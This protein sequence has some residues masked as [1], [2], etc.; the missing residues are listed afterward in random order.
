LSTLRAGC[1][2]RTRVFVP[3]TAREAGPL[4][5]PL[6]TAATLSRAPTSSLTNTTCFDYEKN[7]LRLDNPADAGPILNPQPAARQLRARQPH[8]PRA[9]W[10]DDE[11]I[12]TDRAA[13]D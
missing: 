10:G 9:A 2:H 5:P 1:M 7:L 3:A 11:D 8:A 12:G 6:P 13:H 4:K